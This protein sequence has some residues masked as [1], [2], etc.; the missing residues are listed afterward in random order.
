MVLDSNKQETALITFEVPALLAAFL[1]ILSASI[2]SQLPW[3]QSQ[4]VVVIHCSKLS[5]HSTE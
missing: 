5:S 3:Q 4:R 1:G 2:F